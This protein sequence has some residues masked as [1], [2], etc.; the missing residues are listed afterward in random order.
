MSAFSSNSH[1]GTLSGSES[2]R[3]LS[4]ASF[5][6]TQYSVTEGELS[7]WTSVDQEGARGVNESVG[8]KNVLLMMLARFLRL[9]FRPASICFRNDVGS[10]RVAGCIPPSDFTSFHHLRGSQTFRCSNLYA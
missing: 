2:L 9:D 3:G 6:N 8:A 10:V 7:R 1:A 4:N 5:S